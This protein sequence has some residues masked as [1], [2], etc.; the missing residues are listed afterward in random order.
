MISEA[1][2][3]NICTNFYKQLEVIT[4]L[5]TRKLKAASYTPTKEADVAIVKNE[6][7]LKLNELKDKVKQA[8]SN[9]LTTFIK[10]LDDSIA[11]LQASV[12]ADKDRAAALLAAKERKER[13]QD[14]KVNDM[15]S[16]IDVNELYYFR[17]NYSTLCKIISD[18]GTIKVTEA[19][20]GLSNKN[21]N[22]LNTAF[23]SLT[24]DI[25]VIP[26]RRH[27]RYVAGIILDKNKLAKVL[28]DNHKHFSRNINWA[29]STLNKIYIKAIGKW[30]HNII[31][32]LDVT[33]VEEE[34]A[35]LKILKND[36]DYYYLE[37]FNCG[38]VII[39]ADAYTSLASI[40]QAIIDNRRTKTEAKDIELDTGLYHKYM[41][42]YTDTNNS[43]TLFDIQ[44]YSAE[45]ANVVKYLTT[46]TTLNEHEIRLINDK[47][48]LGGDFNISTAVSGI[49]VRDIWK[50]IFEGEYKGIEL[51]DYEQL[52]ELT[53]NYGLADLSKYLK[54][55][56]FEDFVNF[57]NLYKQHTNWKISYYTLNQPVPEF[58][59]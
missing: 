36:I 4:N 11:E 3:N 43:C 17:Q 45:G 5:Y 32:Y 8:N 54:K 58:K 41:T 34:G 47:N 2:A 42:T 14:A 50:P 13:E 35:G 30:K 29:E 46:C 56:N 12:N 52:Q 19:D 59:N 25:Q 16:S 18:R 40:I 55:D 38:T 10:K 51:K 49:I 37:L 31:E 28:V 26:Q 39:S 20:Y 6:W 9:E 1:K 23:V 33:N 53:N 21:K 15:Q 48:Y 22:E 57:R 24:T 27:T 7:L 44:K